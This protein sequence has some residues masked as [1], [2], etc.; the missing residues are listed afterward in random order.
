MKIG[1]KGLDIP[2]GKNKYEDKFLSA[3]ADKDKPKKISPFF[4]EFLKDARKVKLP[5]I[6]SRFL[7]C[8]VTIFLTP[9]IEIIR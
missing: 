3:L 4:V 6:I 1:F 7:Y 5:K 9:F 8:D 2:D